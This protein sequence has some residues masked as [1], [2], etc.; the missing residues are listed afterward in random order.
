ML[1]VACAQIRKRREFL[2]AKREEARQ[3]SEDG[4]NAVQVRPHCRALTA[5]ALRLCAQRLG[6]GMRCVSCARRRCRCILR[7][8][9]SSIVPPLR[10][11]EACLATPCNA[12]RRLSGCCIGTLRQRLLQCRTGGHPGAGTAAGADV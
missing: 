3:A 5:H 9:S 7:Q 6:S 1:A 2:K 11:L 4:Q 10:D 8:P 12:S